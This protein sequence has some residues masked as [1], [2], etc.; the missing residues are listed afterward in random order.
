M[1]RVTNTLKSWLEP[2][3]TRTVVLRQRRQGIDIFSYCLPCCHQVGDDTIVDAQIALVFAQVADIVAL[4]QK[5]QTP[6]PRFQRV[7]QSC[8]ARANQ[9]FGMIKHS[10]GK[11]GDSGLV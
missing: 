8:M 7:P 4:G 6:R 1:R 5:R 3:E 11:M 10:S 9:A 2:S